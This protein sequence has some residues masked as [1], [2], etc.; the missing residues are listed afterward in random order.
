MGKRSRRKLGVLELEKLY[1]STYILHTFVSPRISTR[2]ESREKVI[3]AK[4]E[5]LNFI[6]SH[7]LPSIIPFT[8]SSSIF[9]SL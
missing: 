8:A 9:P 4:R 3:E 7:I 2:R 6:C 1:P 5:I